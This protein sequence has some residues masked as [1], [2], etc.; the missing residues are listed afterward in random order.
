M[1]KYT[2]ILEYDPEAKAYAVTVPALPGCTSQ[3]DTIEEAISNAKEAIAGHIATLKEIGE[4]VPEEIERP[5]A[6][7]IDVAA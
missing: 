3:G 6:I 5:Q 4:S 1:S 2:I 7:T